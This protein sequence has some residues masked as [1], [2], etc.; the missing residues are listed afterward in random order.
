MKKYSL[1]KDKFKLV[2]GNIDVLTTTGEYEEITKEEYESLKKSKLDFEDLPFEE[3]NLILYECYD[4]ETEEGEIFY[5]IMPEEKPKFE[6]WYGKFDNY[7]NGDYQVESYE[8]Y[9]EAIKAFDERVW[10]ERETIKGWNLR[11]N[12]HLEIALFKVYNGNDEECLK[13][14]I[15]RRDGSMEKFN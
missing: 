12:Q 1:S 7:G 15:V 9:N 3:K 6:I 13:Q 5:V 10:F 11:P 2:D 8:N 4:D 14:V